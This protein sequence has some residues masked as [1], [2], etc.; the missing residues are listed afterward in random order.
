MKSTILGEK[1]FTYFI[2]AVNITIGSRKG[3]TTT[4]VKELKTKYALIRNTET[5]YP[6]V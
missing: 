4:F 6:P 3:E 1:T 2:L 5:F